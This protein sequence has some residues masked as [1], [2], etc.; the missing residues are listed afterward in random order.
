[1]SSNESA[2]ALSIEYAKD[3]LTTRFG[4]FEAYVK[5]MEKEGPEWILPDEEVLEKI[6]DADVL[7]TE[8]GG[9]SSKV[10]AAGKHLKLIVTIRSGFDNINIAFA[11]ERGIKVCIAPSRLAN[12]VADL[13]VALMLSE[14]RGLLRRNLRYTDGEWVDEK[15]NDESHSALCN[16]KIGLVGYGGIARVVARRLV[17]GFGCEVVTYEKFTPLEI[18][19]SDGVKSVSLEALCSSCDIISVH[20]RLTPETRKMIGRKQFALMKPNAIIVNTAR[21][22]LI[23]EEA[24]I[25]AL[26][27]GK[28]R[29]AGLDVYAEE[30]LPKDSKL[31]RMDNVTLMPHSAGITIDIVKNGLSIVIPEIERFLNGQELR[32]SV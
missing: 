5:K 3:T 23:D 18:I 16:L 25:E 10:I 27:S 4:E 29:G 28:I 32:N 17:N 20:A 26:Q 7:L 8:W 30:P 13:T 21:G 22:D 1:M 19:Q 24:L 14:C 2:R 6:A 12:P 9:V 11:R 31:L 15:Y